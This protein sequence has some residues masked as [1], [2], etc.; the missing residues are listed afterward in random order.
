[1]IKSRLPK[2][3]ELYKTVRIGNKEFHILYG[4]Y[5]EEERNFGEP[6]PI[7]PD[8]IANPQYTDDGYLITTHIQ[9]ACRH[10]EIRDGNVGDGWCSDCIHY[11]DKKAEIAICLNCKNRLLT[12]SDAG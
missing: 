2:E 12:E 5:S 7:L 10:Y 6:I 8:F 4:Y 11:H 1:M 9:D 3:G